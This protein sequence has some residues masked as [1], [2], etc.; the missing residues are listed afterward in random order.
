MDFRGELSTAMATAGGGS[1]RWPRSG[2]FLDAWRGHEE[3][4][5]LGTSV[6]PG[7]CYAAKESDGK[8]TAVDDGAGGVARGGALGACVAGA[9]CQGGAGWRKT[10]GA[11]G[12][13]GRGMARGRQLETGTAPDVRLRANAVRKRD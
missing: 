1:K 6:L 13:F 7:V 8:T 11:E 4:D 3:E 2:G 5:E 9:R 10:G 12:G